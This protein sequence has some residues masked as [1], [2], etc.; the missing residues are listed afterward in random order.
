[1][2]LR[3]C[4]GVRVSSELHLIHERHMFLS[5]LEKSRNASVKVFN[6]QYPILSFCQMD[7][8]GNPNA[9]IPH[10]RIIFQV[11]KGPLW[12]RTVALRIQLGLHND[13]WQNSNSTPHLVSNQNMEIHVTHSFHS[14]K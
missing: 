13:R 2:L 4:C 7:H 3:S 14:P 9:L 11:E 12:N 5:E 6:L 1:M 8:T 10:S